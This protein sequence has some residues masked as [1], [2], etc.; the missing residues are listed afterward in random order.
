MWSV[1]HTELP[2]ISTGDVWSMAYF[3]SPWVMGAFD[4]FF[5]NEIGPGGVGLQDRFAQCWQMLAQRFGTHPALLGYDLLNEPAAGSPVSEA[6]GMAAEA[7]I[8]AAGAT[9][10]EDASPF[11]T[12]LFAFS[13]AENDPALFA[14]LIETVGPT[15][16]AIAETRLKPMYRRVTEAIREVDT[17]TPIFIE[18]F[19]TANL[20]LLPQSLRWDGPTGND[21]NLVWAPHIYEADPD[22]AAAITKGL[23]ELGAREHMPVVIGEWGNLD[24]SDGIFDRDPLDGTR[25]ALEILEA[26]GA[27]TMYWAYSRDL[28]REPFFEEFVRRE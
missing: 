26:A 10:P 24:N 18:P 3:E 21:P 13:L 14:V 25:I 19:I 8:T 5:T 17:S 2:H 28:H 27:G 15:L 23:L 7:I 9:P 6:I 4:A 22:R 12:G 20:G 1:L 11:E 16:V